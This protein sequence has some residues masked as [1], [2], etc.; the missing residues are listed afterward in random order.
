MRKRISLL[1]A[2]LVMALSMALS[3]VAFA[4]PNCTGPPSIC[5]RFA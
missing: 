2:T 5:S 3:G 1:I 4:D